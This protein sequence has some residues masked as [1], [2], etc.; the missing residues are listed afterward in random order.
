MGGP[1]WFN[2]QDIKDLIVCDSIVPFKF[3]F[4]SECHSGLAGKTFSSASISHVVF[5]R[6]ESKL[7]DTAALAFT[8]HFYLVLAVGH[9]VKELF[10]LK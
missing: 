5:C 1:N 9:T 6:Q 7:K 3:V 8:R 10:T 2:V 4:V